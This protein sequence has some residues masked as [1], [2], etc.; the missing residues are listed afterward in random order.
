MVRR[1]TA[2]L[3]DVAGCVSAN[4]EQILAGHSNEPWDPTRRR[5]RP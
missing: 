5:L 2:S 4:A 3:Q 1:G